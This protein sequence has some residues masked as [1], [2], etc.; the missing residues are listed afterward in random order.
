M[1]RGVPR[2]GFLHVHSAN[3]VSAGHCRTSGGQMRSTLH[4]RGKIM[5]SASAARRELRAAARLCLPLAFLGSTF[6]T[7][8]VAQQA[9]AGSMQLTLEKAINL[10]LKQNHSIRLRNLSVEQ[11]QSKKDQA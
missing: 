9:S 3:P 8:S 10:A 7:S 2:C 6:V 11:M 4:E 1:L 5:T